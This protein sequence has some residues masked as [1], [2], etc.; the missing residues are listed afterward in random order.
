MQHDGLLV[1][2]RAV[3]DLQGTYQVAVVDPE[4]KISIRSVKV[5]DRVDNDW[6]ITE[7]LQRGET[8][9]AEGVQKVSTGLLVKQKPFARDAQG[10]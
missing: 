7:G 6:I 8:V 4:N 10:R 1:P 9:V 2:Q 5:G 3:S